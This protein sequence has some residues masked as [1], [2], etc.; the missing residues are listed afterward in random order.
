MQF[1]HQGIVSH[2]DMSGDGRSS[3]SR[4]S[5]TTRHNGFKREESALHIQIAA[6]KTVIWVHA[7]SIG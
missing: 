4:E 7:A 3:V 1:T 5:M 6:R 2:S